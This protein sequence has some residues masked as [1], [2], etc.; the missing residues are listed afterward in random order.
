[1]ARMVHVTSSWRLRENEAE[2]GR[3]DG[4]RCRTVEVSRKYPSLAIISSS[5]HRGILVFWFSL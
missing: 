5:A 1:M 4:V 2:D 3:S